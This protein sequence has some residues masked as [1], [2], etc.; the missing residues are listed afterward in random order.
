MYGLSLQAFEARKAAIADVQ[1]LWPDWALQV[2]S[3]SIALPSVPSQG[4]PPPHYPLLSLRM[5]PANH[6]TMCI[7]FKNHHNP[8]GKP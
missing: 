5:P 8:E 3:M 4:P 7:Q 6:D 1:G 2:M